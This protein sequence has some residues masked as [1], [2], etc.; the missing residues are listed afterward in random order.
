MYHVQ[1][2][3]IQHSVGYHVS[4]GVCCW[5]C[6]LYVLSISEAIYMCCKSDR[7]VQVAAGSLPASQM[8][9]KH[10]L[11]PLAAA[12]SH[13]PPSTG[14]QHQE[15]KPHQTQQQL[16]LSVIL[17]IVTAAVKAAGGAGATSSPEAMPNRRLCSRKQDAGGHDHAR[18]CEGDPMG[19]T[20]AAVLEAVIGSQRLQD[21]SS[22]N[23]GGGGGATMPGRQSDGDAEMHDSA[24]W[25]QGNSSQQLAREMPSSNGTEHTN[26]GDDSEEDAVQLLQLQVLTELVSFPATSSP[27]SSQVCCSGC[28]HARVYRLP[29]RYD[30]TCVR[31]SGEQRHVLKLPICMCMVNQ[32]HTP[33][34]LVCC[35]SCK[36]PW[37]W[38]WNASEAQA[39]MAAQQLCKRY[40]L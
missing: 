18:E 7:C 16:A 8:T 38:C 9:C 20:G 10:L 26:G 15:H 4:S 12:A 14:Q 23:P 1:T 30:C 27:L 40:P 5:A 22:A 2:S 24:G 17:A 3:S 39:A 31:V 28:R 35:R 37:P 13:S 6:M 34:L 11:P 25:M 21:H 19:G 33:A 36:K 29:S 32:Q